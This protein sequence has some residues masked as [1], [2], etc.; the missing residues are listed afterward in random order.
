MKPTAQPK[1]STT[2]RETGTSVNDG[3]LHEKGFKVDTIIVESETGHTYQIVSLNA[4]E[5]TV[6]CKLLR[7]G[8]PSTSGK[9]KVSSPPQKSTKERRLHLHVASALLLIHC[10][11]CTCSWCRTR[12]NYIQAAAEQATSNS[13][14][15]YKGRFRRFVL[16][17]C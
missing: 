6:S 17:S 14:A 7:V 5:I 13:A 11:V 12:D 2:L 4:D 1:R 16:N 15:Y 9:K 3:L 10:T 8:T